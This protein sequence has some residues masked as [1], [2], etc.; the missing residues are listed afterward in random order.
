MASNPTKM[1]DTA[2]AAAQLG[3]HERTV[4]RYVRAGQL[5]CLVLPGGRY[6]FSE[7]HIRQCSERALAEKRHPHWRE[8]K[9]PKQRKSR[10]H[11]PPLGL[12]PPPKQRKSRPRRP[13]LGSEP[14]PSPFDLSDDAL[15]DIRARNAGA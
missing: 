2:W 8:A 7:D 14:A 12:P 13:P 6:R 9:P 15:D 5:E 1:H 4:R 10:H 11:R 3:V